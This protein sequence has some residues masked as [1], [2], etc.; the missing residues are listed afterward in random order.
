MPTNVLSFV[1]NTARKEYPAPSTRLA[2]A[3]RSCLHIQSQHVGAAALPGNALPGFG[4]G[5]LGKSS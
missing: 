4:R 3:R 2:C 5:L 1:Q